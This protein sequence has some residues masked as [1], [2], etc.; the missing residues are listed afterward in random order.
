MRGKNWTAA[1][2]EYLE[3][4]WG[5]KTITQIAK[6]LGRTVTAIALKSKRLGLTGQLN[7]GNLM[8]AR[9]V[10]NLMHVDIHAV[11]DYWIAKCD[12]KAKKQIV[13]NKKLIFVIKFDDLILWL[14]ANQDK[15][16]SRRLETYELGM[17][18]DWLKKKRES[19]RQLPVRRFQKWTRQED[20]DGGNDVSEGIYYQKNCRAS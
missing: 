11:T 8:S 2:I 13:R 3:D 6:R 17:E 10:S 5:E 15:W 18:Y 14:K 19:D 12:L 1:E 20:N 7:T 9:Y 16:D 4:S